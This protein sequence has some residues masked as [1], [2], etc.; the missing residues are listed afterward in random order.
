MA[1]ERVLAIFAHPDDECIVAGGTLKACS[2]SGLETIVISLTR[3]E[4][5]SIAHPNL[6]TNETLDAVPEIIDER[7]TDGQ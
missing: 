3:G 1:V 6:A 4:Q 7:L 5:G 2:E